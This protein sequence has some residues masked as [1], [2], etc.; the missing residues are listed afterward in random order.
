MCRRV[1]HHAAA[2]QNG[3]G[4]KR[5]QAQHVNR[6]VPNVRNVARRQGQAWSE[7]QL[8]GESKILSK[9]PETCEEKNQQTTSSKRCDLQ[10][11]I[12]RKQMQ[13]LLSPPFCKEPT[14]AP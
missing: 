10:K 3:Q 2:G 4:E 12:H 9:F 7:Q 11:R 5:E 8:D 1:S 6:G 13:Q 14:R